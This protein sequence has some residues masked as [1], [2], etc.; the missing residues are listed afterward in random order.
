M[1]EPRE[2]AFRHA[3]QKGVANVYAVRPSPVLAFG[4]GRFSH[5]S[6]RL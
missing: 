1:F 5:T 3:D 4:K 6:H 2:G